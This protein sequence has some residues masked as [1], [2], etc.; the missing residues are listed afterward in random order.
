MYDWPK[1]Y[2]QFFIKVCLLLGSSAKAMHDI[3]TTCHRIAMIILL[4]PMASLLAAVNALIF[5]CL[6]EE[7]NIWRQSHI[8]YSDY[9]AMR[10]LG[11][12]Y[13]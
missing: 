1:W 9:C 2:N 10:G 11:I 12:Y 13:H 4:L 7:Y 6:A 3:I 5:L 8:S